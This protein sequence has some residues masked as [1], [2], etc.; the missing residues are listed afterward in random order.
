MVR[1]VPLVKQWLTSCTVGELH[2]TSESYSYESYELKDTIYNLYQ[3]V[4]IGYGWITL[5]LI[6][7]L[8][9]RK[10]DADCLIAQHYFLSMLVHRLV[11][12]SFSNRFFSN[13]WPPYV[14]IN[15]ISMHS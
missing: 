12:L 6:S 1:L 13:R 9:S 10:Y 2:I 8:C 5:T 3:F 4:Y 15:M 14:L 7:P 11:K